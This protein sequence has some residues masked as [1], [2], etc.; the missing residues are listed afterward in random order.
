V[1]GVKIPVK[2]LDAAIPLP[3][4]ARSGDAGVDLFARRGGRIAPGE[5]DL[6]PAGIAVAIPK[7]YVGLIAPRSGLATR[8]GIGLV[9]APGVLD[10][11]FRGEIHALLVNG[12]DEP[13]QFK[14]GERIAQL[15]VVPCVQLEFDPVDELPTS[16]RGEGG[17]G[18]TGA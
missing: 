4:H 3:T 15:V 13:F 14:R 17:F 6:V 1:H 10:S 11:G 16:Q 2:R 12:G 8:H 5:R 9:N 7:G 18:S